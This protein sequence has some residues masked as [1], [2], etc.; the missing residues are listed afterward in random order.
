MFKFSIIIPVF[1]NHNIFSLFIHSLLDSLEEKTQIILINDASPEEVSKEICNLK[2]I[3][4]NVFSIQTITHETS[5][6]C[7]KSINEA[8]LL[9]KGE[10]IVLMDS[11]VIV[12]KN[13]QKTVIKSFS[14][15]EI[16]CV[17][18]VL[19]YPQT[20]GI[21]CCGITYTCGTGRHL[22]LNAPPESVGNNI[23]EVQ[24]SVFAF[25]TIKIEVINKI[26]F[27]N[28]QFFNGY[29]DWDYQM[30]IRQAGYKIIINPIIQFYHWEKSNGVHRAY[31][32]KSNL[33]IFWKKH[34]YFIKEDLWDFIFPQI[35]RLTDKNDFIGID[36]CSSRLDAETFWRQAA[37]RA[38]G[39]ISDF[40]DYS[41]QI[42]DNKPIWLL[43]ILHYDFFIT[44][45]K[46]LFLCDNFVQLTG[47]YYWI[48]LRER[49]CQDDIIVDLY[50]NVTSFIDLTSTCWPGNKIR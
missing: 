34:G 9:A 44:S 35:N 30:R 38:P 39:L 25:L 16:G 11:D 18:G 22:K 45:S 28:D 46:F 6:G 40:L 26:G 48:K 23:Y 49:Y 17:G 27:L 20:N 42:E 19:L 5:M 4:N 33:G 43:D 3:R 15:P 50:G 12:K 1:Q 10:F 36:I 14:T 7:A 21:Q 8:F 13:W 47:N 41:Y 24:A 32:R 37:K 31:N 2:Q 29:E